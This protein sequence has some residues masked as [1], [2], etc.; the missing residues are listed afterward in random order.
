MLYL[1]QTYLPPNRMWDGLYAEGLLK[2]VRPLAGRWR[3]ACMRN[4]SGAEGLLDVLRPSA[5]SVVVRVWEVV[6]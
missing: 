4:G 2:G 5:G 6:N 1:P 3:S